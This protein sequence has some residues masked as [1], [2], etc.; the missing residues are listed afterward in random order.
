MTINAYEDAIR[1]TWRHTEGSLAGKQVLQRELVR[2]ATLAP[3]S[4]NTQCWKFAL[5]DRGISIMPDLS[6][7]CPAVDPDDHHLFVSLGCAAENLAQA[8]R[9]NGMMGEVHFDSAAGGVV[10]VI[11]EPT[12]AIS[13]PLFQA[14]PHRQCSRAAYDGRPLSTGDL[15]QLEQAGHGKGVSVL[16]LIEK[17]RIETVIEYVVQGNTLQIQDPTFVQE[18]KAWVRFSD[19]EAVRTGD[20]LFSRSMGNPAV[21]RWLGS[22]FLNLFLTPKNE[23][24]KYVKH[25]RSASGLAVFVSE[26]DDTSHWVEAGRCYERFALQA[27]ALGIRNAFVNQ[28]VEVAALRPQFA[29][30][31]GL[32][33]RRPDLI[34]R[35]GHGPEMPRSL[36]RPIDSVIA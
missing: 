7:R 25:I 8:G 12:K 1:Q 11:L 9:A 5:D 30:A 13:T 4:H 22:L 2:Y 20:G 24:D 16:L 34:V 17:S 3:S 15:K 28:P 10:R 36:R 29:S 27:A 26:V 33:G 35:F 31:L 14:I 23:N 6:R 32:G 21:P 18:L 19:D